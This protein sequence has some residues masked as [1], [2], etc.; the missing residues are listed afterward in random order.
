MRN[1]I[2]I[3]KNHK[4][5]RKGCKTQSGMAFVWILVMLVLVS[6]LSLSFLKKTVIGTSA[7]VSR[8]SSIKTHYL[9]RSGANHA[10]WRLLN[11]PTF[12]PTETDYDMHDFGEGRYGYK[13]RKPTLTEFG[14]V[15]TVGA[16]DSTVTKQS[17]V[18][19]LKPYNIIAAYDRSSGS[20]PKKQKAIW[21]LLGRFRRLDR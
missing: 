1:F 8:L 13:V 3:R 6:A 21:R 7:V 9:T 11:D 15:A 17:Y 10:L 2:E 20:V 14:T 5:W 4:H 18:Q 16:V 12:S 19:Y